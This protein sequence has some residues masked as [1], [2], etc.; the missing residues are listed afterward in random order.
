MIEKQLKNAANEKIVER[1]EESEED[2][3]I[4]FTLF[5]DGRIVSWAKT[6]LYSYLKE[7]HTARKEKRKGFGR[8]LL[9]YME[10]N[11]KAH[12]ATTIKTGDI[13]PCSGEAI[14]FFI[15]M[16]YKVKPIV[17]YATVFLEGTKR[18]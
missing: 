14:S 4:T 17:N 9:A 6:L 5:V 3:E 16:G 13:D 15:S 18:L 7:I 11:A 10:K 8:K 2:D 12:G 1:Q